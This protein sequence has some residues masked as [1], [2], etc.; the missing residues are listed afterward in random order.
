MTRPPFFA[1]PVHVPVRGK[2]I[3]R[4]GAGDGDEIGIGKVGV[5]K[6]VADTICQIGVGR[7]VS[8]TIGGWNVGV[9]GRAGGT[10][11]DIRRIARRKAALAA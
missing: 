5:W 11:A 7:G 4:V 8:V 6:G 9:G 2:A 1:L 3:C 10:Q